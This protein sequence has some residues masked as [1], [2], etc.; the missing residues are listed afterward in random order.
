MI[1]SNKTVK[2]SIK[3]V[4]NYIVPCKLTEPGYA[5]SLSRKNIAT[6]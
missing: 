1:Y 6:C 2:Y 5:A 3:A 4:N